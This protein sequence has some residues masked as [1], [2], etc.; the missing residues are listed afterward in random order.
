MVADAPISTRIIKYF[1][2]IMLTVCITRLL[3]Y[4][5][6]VLWDPCMKV[7]HHVKFP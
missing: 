6:S 5:L 3:D 4:G 2:L 1:N 7:I